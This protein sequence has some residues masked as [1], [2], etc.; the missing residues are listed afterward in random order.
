MGATDHRTGGHD[1]RHTR[2]VDE[3]PALRRDHWERTSPPSRAEVA[4]DRIA[5]RIARTQTGT[6]LGTK[7]ELRTECGVSV[8]T[9]NE[10]LRL[11]QTRGLVTVRP[12]PGGGLFA[13]QPPPPTGLDTWAQTLN[14]QDPHDALRVRNALDPLLVEDAL[15]H[16]SPADIAGLRH[17]LAALAEAVDADATAFACA[18]RQLRTALSCLSPSALLRSLYAS[19]L[20]A[21]ELVGRTMTPDEQRAAYERFAALVDALDT[22]DRPQALRLAS[23]PGEPRENPA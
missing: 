3:P 9:F 2:D 5:D 15:W 8:G 6:R 23:A 19:L 18:D 22:R 11:L 7:D 13:A 14:E 21:L 12:G 17:H 10:A 4:A 16:A 1:A 20:A